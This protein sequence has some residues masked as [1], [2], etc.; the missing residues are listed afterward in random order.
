MKI[1]TNENKFDHKI[2]QNILANNIEFNKYL[3]ELI[4]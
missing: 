1:L 3:L 4:T 2:F